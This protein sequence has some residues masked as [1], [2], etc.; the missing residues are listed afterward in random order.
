MRL[1]NAEKLGH[2][3][4]DDLI[5][6]AICERIVKIIHI[7]HELSQKIWIVYKIVDKQVKI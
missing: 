6:P 5:T 7:I 2:L 3:T 4:S 1:F